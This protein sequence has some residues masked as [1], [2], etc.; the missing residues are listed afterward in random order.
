MNFFFPYSHFKY[1]SLDIVINKI[2]E[3]KLK[4]TDR[5]TKSCIISKKQLTDEI[6]NAERII[7]N[8]NELRK[9]IPNMTLFN[10]EADK[11]LTVK[12]KT[13]IQEAIEIIQKIKERIK[14]DF[15]MIIQ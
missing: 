3:N 15:S 4:R 2:K 11:D 8:L 6:C 13:K 9:D 10:L 12:A 14:L 5:I 1:I 7:E